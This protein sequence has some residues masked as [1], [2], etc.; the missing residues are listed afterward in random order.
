[1]RIILPMC[2]LIPAPS[3]W[4]FLPKKNITGAE[5]VDARLA[6]GPEN[7]MRPWACFSACRSEVFLWTLFWLASSSAKWGRRRDFFQAI[8]NLLYDMYFLNSV[9]YFLQALQYLLPPN[10]SKFKIVFYK[11]ISILIHCIY[12]YI[13]NYN[14][15]HQPRGQHIQHHV[16]AGDRNLRIW[17][18]PKNN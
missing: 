17:Y 18:V 3:R 13:C 2:S 5:F 9:S 6:F 11:S 4:D 12:I 15:F 14:I 1:M 10:I 7:G 8:L 16:E